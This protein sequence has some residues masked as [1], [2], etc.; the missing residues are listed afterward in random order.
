MIPGGSVPRRRPLLLARAGQSYLNEHACDLCAV[1][2]PF[3]MYNVQWPIVARMSCQPQA[4]SSTKTATGPGGAVNSV[5]ST[6]AIVS[7]GLVSNSVLSPGVRV[8]SRSLVNR[9]VIL[10]N[11]R[12]H[13]NAV[14][15]NAILDKDVA[16]FAGRDRRGGQEHDRARGFTVSAGGVTVVGK[17]RMA[18]GAA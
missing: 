7:G 5:V 13:A 17:G 6:G 10:H 2:P 14:V 1:I 12:V 4:S 9:A 11:T 15:A 18:R 8:D 16:V 3:N